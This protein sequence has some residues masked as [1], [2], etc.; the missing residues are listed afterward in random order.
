MMLSKNFQN[1]KMKKHNN[2]K[3]YVHKAVKQFWIL[4]HI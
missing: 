2:I 1:K 4:E 3:N